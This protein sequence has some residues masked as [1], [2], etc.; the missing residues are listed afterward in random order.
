[1][2]NDK[3]IENLINAFVEYRNL[4]S[5]I[6]QNLKNFADT[7]ENM[8]ED[9]KQLNQSFD[10]NIPKKLDAIYNDIFKQFEKSKDLSS[11]IDS[12]KQKTDKFSSQMD[13]LIELFSNIE[14][15][16]NRIDDIE[17]RVTN[18]IDK[19]ESIVDKKS[20]VYNIKELE[21]NLET[22]TES[23]QKINDYIN[24]DIGVMLKN[25][26]EKLS[27]IRDKNESVLENL[28]NEKNN[29]EDLISKY[30]ESNKLIKKVF[31]K[32]DVN[33][34]VIF[35]LLDKWASERGVKTKK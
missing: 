3:E 19:L 34:Q 28:L 4:L 32:E 8:R 29:I 26:D 6:E 31:E 13:K 25:N 15:K 17:K 1:M 16:I 5:P 12:F 11:Q 35:D 10:G 20:K 24:K 22:Y 2:E 30:D 21:K 33:E 9:I 23:V 14:N 7:Y 27:L 18:Q